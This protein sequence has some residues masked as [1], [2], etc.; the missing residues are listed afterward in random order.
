MAKRV[1][2][3]VLWFFAG[4]YLGSYVSAFMGQPDL[5]GPL[6]GACAAILIAGDPRHVIWDRA[7][8]K[9]KDEGTPAEAPSAA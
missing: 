6:W 4:W 1:A 9:P 2:A 3:A 5:L 7:P 8:A